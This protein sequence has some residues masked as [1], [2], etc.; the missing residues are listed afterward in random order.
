MTRSDIEVGDI[1]RAISRQ[2]DVIYGLMVKVYPGT[3]GR[4]ESFHLKVLKTNNPSLC[5]RKWKRYDMDKG[6]GA[7]VRRGQYNISLM[8]KGRSV[9]KYVK[10]DITTASVSDLSIGSNV[11][12]KTTH[13]TYVVYTNTGSVVNKVPP[14]IFVV[15]KNSDGSEFGGIQVVPYV[16]DL[17]S[18]KYLKSATSRCEKNYY[19]SL[20]LK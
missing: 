12:R 20:I 1:V 8:S 16:S 2:G 4:P 9:L 13:V 6:W 7:F 3:E 15:R 11:S 5:D 18:L 10:S 19:E 14:V 17:N